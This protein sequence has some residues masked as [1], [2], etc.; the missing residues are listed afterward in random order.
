MTHLFPTRRA[1][2]LVRASAS[3]ASSTGCR[4]PRVVMTLAPARPSCSG[5]TTTSQ[6]A[7]SRR[8]SRIWT[9]FDPTVRRRREASA[10]WRTQPTARYGGDERREEEGR[11]GDEWCPQERI[12][13]ERET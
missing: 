9:T 8:G 10:Y 13:L 5:A 1:S 6:S 11:D 2:D 4:P 12:R 7:G 3:Q